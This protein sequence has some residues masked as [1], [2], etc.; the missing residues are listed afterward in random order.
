MTDRQITA[1]VSAHDVGV[2]SCRSR[3]SK[4]GGDAAKPGPGGDDGPFRGSKPAS[5][6]QSRDDRAESDLPSS[7]G[8][9]NPLLLLPLTASSICTVRPISL[10]RMLLTDR[11]RDA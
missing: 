9:A 6:A 11:I 8:L 3:I 10:L 4:A 2:A 1:K 7:D 5:L